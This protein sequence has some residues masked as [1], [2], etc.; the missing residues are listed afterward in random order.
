MKNT[1]IVLCS[2]VLIIVCLCSFRYYRFGVKNQVDEFIGIDSTVDYIYNTRDVKIAYFY[3]KFEE[4]DESNKVL[5]ILNND[6]F[7]STL[8]VVKCRIGLYTDVDELL[9]YKDY[10]FTLYGP[11]ESEVE[12]IV[13]YDKIL[14][15]LT[16]KEGYYLRF[17]IPSE[18]ENIDIKIPCRQDKKILRQQRMKELKQ[19][20]KFG[21]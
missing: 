12:C 2:F 21:V 10:R 3:D 4:G 19:A 16:L 8:G 7:N 15:Q 9:C 20:V 11:T 1:K 6:R 17:L 13:G 18:N 5:I 14:R